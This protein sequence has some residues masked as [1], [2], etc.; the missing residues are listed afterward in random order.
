MT[1]EP[2]NQEG[3]CS[4]YLE[5]LGAEIIVNYSRVD[6]QRRY[7]DTTNLIRIALQDLARRGIAH[8]QCLN[9]L[10]PTLCRYVFVTCD[11]AYNTSIDFVYQPICRRSCEILS[12]FVC[13]RVWELL[14]QQ[15]SNLNFDV[16]DPPRCEPLRNP[17]GGDVP[18]CIDA[19]NGGNPQFYP[20]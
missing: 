10:L 12:H 7:A 14:N 6:G 8:K 11:P 5:P 16:L 19:T 2:Y 1:C 18:D 15:L 20:S 3:F 4:E 9:F 13:I 17:N